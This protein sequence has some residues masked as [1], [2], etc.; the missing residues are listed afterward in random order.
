[1]VREITKNNKVYYMC[2]ACNMVYKDKEMAQK[3]E[4]YCN[5]HHSCNLEI[6]KYAIKI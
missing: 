4:D 5:K 6:I 2:E 3:C 1:M